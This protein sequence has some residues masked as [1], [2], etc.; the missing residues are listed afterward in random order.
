MALAAIALGA[1]ISLAVAFEPH[2]NAAYRLEFGLLVANLL[3]YTLFLLIALSRRQRW[4]GFLG[5]GLVSAHAALLFWP[6]VVA[7]VW[8][9]AAT[10]HTVPVLLALVLIPLVILT[11]RP[12]WESVSKS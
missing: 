2:F 1:V 3:P 10:A 9:Y 6:A 12:E 4:V 11:A 7:V 8:P 5:L